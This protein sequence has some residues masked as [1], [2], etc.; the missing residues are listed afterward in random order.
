M[1][2]MRAAGVRLIDGNQGARL[3]RRED[4]MGAKM[5]RGFRR[6][7]SVSTKESHS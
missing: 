4:G 3:Y 1:K 6:S 2:T 5:A 7:A